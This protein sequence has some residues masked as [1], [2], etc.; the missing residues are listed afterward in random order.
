[1]AGLPVN[2]RV[3]IHF[4]G[5]VAL[6]GLLSACSTGLSE[7][8]QSRSANAVQ[9]N[10]TPKLDAENGDNHVQN[11]TDEPTTISLKEALENPKSTH[12]GLNR[13]DIELKQ[14]LDSLDKSVEQLTFDEAWELAL[15]NDSGYQ[16]AI[17]AKEAAQTQIA[18][19]RS[20]LLPQI[21]AGYSR[22]KLK[23]MQRQAS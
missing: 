10:E 7:Y 23:G 2:N 16:A 4:I 5:V 11:I 8:F 3:G 14:V 13:P 21:S 19:G 18:Q 20:Q 15:K 12:A 17:S 6:A 1:M 22:A 9:T